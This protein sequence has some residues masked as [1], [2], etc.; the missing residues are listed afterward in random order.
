ML[1]LFAA[2]VV[3]ALAVGHYAVN[4]IRTHFGT[5]FVRAHTLLQRQKL[6]A[7]LS[8][9]IAVAQRFG[10]LAATE[11]WLLDETDPE[12]LKALLRDAEPFRR[13]FPG[14]E[15][16]IISDRTLNYYVHDGKRDPQVP[17]YTLRST[18]A[19]DAWFF[20]TR[21]SIGDYA[22]NVNTDERLKVT[23]VWINVP[24]RQ[25]GRFIGL[26]S[27]GIDLSRFMGE[28]V[29]SPLTGV[30][31]ILVN[32]EGVIQAHPDAS[33]IEYGAVSKTA[34]DKTLERLVTERD[35]PAL[36]QALAAARSS[37]GD[38]AQ[39]LNVRLQ[40]QQRMLGIVYVPEVDWYVV[41]AVDL[42]TAAVLDERWLLTLSA[43]VLAVMV[44]LAA[45]LTFGIDRM[46]LNPLARLHRSVAQMSRGNYDVLLASSRKDELGDLTRAFSHMAEEIRNHT[47]QL[48]QRIQERTHALAQA[49][50]E[51]TAA[52]GAIQDS[53]RYASLIQR[54]ILPYKPLAESVGEDHFLL[55]APR[56]EVGGDFFVFR[57]DGQ[58]CMIGVV[59][60]AGHGVPGALMTMIGRTAFDVA[61]AEVGLGNP[62]GVLTRMDDVVRTMMH[63]DEAVRGIATTMD[64]ALCAVD[65]DAGTLSFAGARL[66]LCWSDGGQVIQVAGSR[67]CIADRK[68]PQFVNHEMALD[69]GATY[70]L[71]TDGYLDQSGGEKGLGFGRRRFMAL[72]QQVAGEPMSVQ[73]DAFADALAQYQG[74]RSQRDDI[75]VLAFR[76]GPRA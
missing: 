12:R 21:E 41:S 7:L 9:E 49:N 14:N 51:V 11:D 66:G 62:A 32:A 34:S 17:S 60:C 18:E 37:T 24:V 47:Q 38:D 28:F 63:H 27:S 52:H 70:Y 75:T 73:R 68:P 20:A 58:R 39:N 26:V 76:F 8:R 53:L 64:A 13:T 74:S 69:T 42:A 23:R 55:W 25:D 10:S 3:A 36:V 57:A 40:G 45:L 50:R 22:L 46:V 72:I 15:Y 56:D 59:D 29:R 61:V 33:L 5:E 19:A 43:I 71:T 4:S 65:L 6:S 1:A 2:L 48:E 16:S 31:N 35:Q 67:S 30:T 54:G 44:L